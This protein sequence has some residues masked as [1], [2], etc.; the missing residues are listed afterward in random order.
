MHKQDKEVEVQPEF[1]HK[2]TDL[3]V[4]KEFWHMVLGQDVSLNLL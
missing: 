1:K 3:R 2:L 4:G